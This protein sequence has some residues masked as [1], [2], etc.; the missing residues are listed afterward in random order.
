MLRNAIVL[1]LLWITLISAPTHSRSASDATRRATAET[2]KST[3]TASTA[4][5]GSVARLRYTVTPSA[6]AAS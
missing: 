4:A 2:T 1:V 3:A 5:I 6:R